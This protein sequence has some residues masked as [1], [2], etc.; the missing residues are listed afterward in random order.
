MKIA[1]IEFIFESF[2]DAKEKFSADTSTEEVN[3]YIDQFKE[4]ANKNIITGTE[5]DIGKWI[6]SG[7]NDFKK[8]VDSKSEEKSKSEVKKSKKKD[9]ITAY[10]DDNKMVI[11]PLTQ[12]A[13]C[14]YGK[15]TK[16]CTAST[17]S[18]NYFSDYFYNDNVVLFYVLMVNGVK[19][20][21]A[22]HLEKEM[23]EYFDDQ[24]ITIDG[25]EFKHATGISNEMIIDLY[26]QNKE[27]IKNAKDINNMSDDQQITM[28]K[29]N[30]DMFKKIN[31]P[32]E[33][34]QIA[35]VKF[36]GFLIQYIDNPSEQVQIEAVQESGNN[37][38]YLIKNG[39]K[40]SEDVQ[41]VAVN[42]DT[43]SVQYIKGPSEKVQ[44]LAVH[45]NTY[46]IKY[47]KNPTEK[48][49]LKAINQNAKAIMYVYNPSDEAKIAAIKK[50]E[51]AIE[52]MVPNDE[53]KKLHRKLYGS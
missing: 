51:D 4:L 34:V 25:G 7:W 36:L 22:Y 16:W 6:K 20:A 11:I 31:N 38:K 53:H 8:F 32:S 2:K 50:S 44:L 15:N 5:K 39:I 35:A 30:S 9:S 40:A 3:K 17:Q 1:D 19:Y 28:I 12:N 14:Y 24:D 27:V 47:L 41:L 49:I 48:V 18:K 23:M 21:A 13:S 33:K 46:A 42:T 52:Y 10:Q 26:N 29:N 43:E 37:I 45:K